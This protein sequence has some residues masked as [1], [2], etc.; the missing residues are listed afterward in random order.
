MFDHCPRAR[1]FTGLKNISPL[2]VH[3]ID[4]ECT[5]LNRTKE[6]LTFFERVKSF[7]FA[8]QIHF[9]VGDVEH[10][11]LHDTIK[12]INLVIGVINTYD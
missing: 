2:N 1:F 5:G 11:R 8:F 7:K 4:E 12:T 10:D 9:I 3:F 6:S